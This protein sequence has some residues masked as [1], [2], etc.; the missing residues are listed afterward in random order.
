MLIAA[1]HSNWADTGA[2]PAALG[3]DILEL[4]RG[5]TKGVYCITLLRQAYT[6]TQA[7]FRPGFILLGPEKEHK[8]ASAP[9]LHLWSASEYH[10]HQH[11]M[12]CRQLKLKLPCREL[13]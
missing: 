13:A 1:E 12:P 3:R 9:A 10:L 6:S 7:S 11:L 8:L 4:G 2:Q 5:E